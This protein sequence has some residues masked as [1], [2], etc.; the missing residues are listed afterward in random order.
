MARTPKTP[1]PPKPAKAK[2]AE[3]APKTP[4]APKPAKASRKAG[5]VAGP[6]ASKGRGKG[7]KNAEPDGPVEV[8]LPPFTPVPPGVDLLP[9]SIREGVM[10]R[11]VVN[12]TIGIGIAAMVV[13]TMVFL[14]QQGLIVKAQSDLNDEQGRASVLAKQAKKYLPVRTYFSQIESNALQIATNMSKEVAWKNT[15]DT[16]LDVAKSG[17]V[18][19]DEVAIDIDT[20]V[21]GAQNANAPATEATE[22]AAGCPQIDLFTENAPAVGCAKISGTAATR[23]DL[24]DWIAAME[25]ESLF[26]SPFI[27]SSTADTEAGITF[28]ASVGVTA[29]AFTFRYDADYLK[30]DT[31]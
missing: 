20:S 10:I 21:G 27:S 25:D 8:V 17:P 26:V 31:Q 4:K 15:F 2:K 3:K 23:S 7:K 18:T 9:R 1:K 30:G 11:R 12:Q 19:I 6:K 24:S 16:T 29:K 22:V 14:S 13:M 28:S 5:K